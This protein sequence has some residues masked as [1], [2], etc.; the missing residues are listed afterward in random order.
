MNG[1]HGGFPDKCAYYIPAGWTD[2][3]G[4]QTIGFGACQPGSRVPAGG[5]DSGSAVVSGA[6]SEVGGPKLEVSRG[7]DHAF[8]RG[9]D[10]AAAGLAAGISTAKKDARARVGKRQVSTW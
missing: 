9:P 5:A 8:T 7:L 3:F 4:L 1:Y 6:D 2:W 10:F